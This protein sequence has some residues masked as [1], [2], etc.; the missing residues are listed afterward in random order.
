MQTGKT[1]SLI[2]SLPALVHY[3]VEHSNVQ[4]TT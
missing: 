2:S 4:M 3:V 1:V